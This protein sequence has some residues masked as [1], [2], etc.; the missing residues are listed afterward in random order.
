MLPLFRCVLRD[1]WAGA[2]GKLRDWQ[3]VAAGWQLLKAEM[4]QGTCTA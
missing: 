3:E 4:P 2:L 1:S